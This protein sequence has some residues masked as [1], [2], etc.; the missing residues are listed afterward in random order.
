MCCLLVQAKK[1]GA[2]E[3]AKL[4]KMGVSADGVALVGAL[5]APRQADRISVDDALNHRWFSE[6]SGDVR[7]VSPPT[8]AC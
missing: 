8:A 6:P 1:G 5:M 7:A 3:L 2:T 4:R